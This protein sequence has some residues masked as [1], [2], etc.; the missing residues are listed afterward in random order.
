MKINKILF[1]IVF[2]ILLINLV[3]AG[4]CG[5]GGIDV[6]EQCD[7]GNND[8]GDGCTWWCAME[9]PSINLISPVTNTVLT[10]RNVSFTCSAIAFEGVNNLTLYTNISG[11]WAAVETRGNGTY[12]PTGRFVL[13]ENANQTTRTGSWSSGPSTSDGVWTTEGHSYDGTSALSLN[14]T[15]PATVLNSSLWRVKDYGGEANLTIPFDCWNYSSTNLYL[16]AYSNTPLTAWWTCYNGTSYKTLRTWTGTYGRYIYE[17][18]M[19]W[20]IPTTNAYETFTISNVPLGTYKW[21]CEACNVTGGALGCNF[22][23]ANYSF[24]IDYTLNPCNV[25]DYTLTLN[26]TVKDETNF[27]NM[28]ASADI[29]LNYG[30]NNYSQDRTYS[31][32]DHLNNN[33][34]FRV[35][36]FP[37]YTSFYITG[38]ISYFSPGYDRRDYWF[39]QA[40]I[41]NQT[42]NIPLYLA[43]TASTDIFT[44]TVKDEADNQVKDA[45][46][47]VERWDIGTNNFYTV[48]V[49]KTDING[50]AFINMRL[51]DAWYRYKVFY[52]NILYLTT[53][54]VKE[55]TT[56]RTLRINIGSSTP[57]QN[58]ENNSYSIINGISHLLTFNN[59]TNTFTFVYA[60]STGLTNIGCLEMSKMFMNTTTSIYSSCIN[61]ASGT[62]S[63]IATDNATYVA[64]GSITLNENFSNYRS[65]VDTLVVTIGKPQRFTVI[66]TYGRAVSLIA[67]GTMALLGVASGSIILGFG[68]IILTA[69]GLDLIGFLDFT[70]ANSIWGSVIFTIISI[71]IMV[72]I[73][74]VRRRGE[75]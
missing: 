48:G 34:N 15:K 16:R 56:S 55:S 65:I 73:T 54:P 26:F 64:Y 12:Y 59:D 14:Y 28:N 53:D 57:L 58:G 5:D 33:S 51:N 45:Y 43:T 17:E 7:D 35:C 36:M 66:A 39:N 22:A 31:Y 68:L 32:F 71:I 1:S 30:V 23:P 18:A 60:D 25:S 29:T 10:S 38:L 19:L 41:S 27:S 8:D 46:I 49:I 72:L 21:N 20:R 37:N 50:N 69:I 3:S 44:F 4:Y 6:G 40:H 74:A 63:Y 9:A 70:S 52:N 67:I 24:T 47:Y 11:T 42:Q 13:Q 62:L 75:T 61:S 2:M